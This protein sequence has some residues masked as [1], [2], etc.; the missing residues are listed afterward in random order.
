MR[1]FLTAT[2]A[3]TLFTAA[4]TFAP[5]TDTIEDTAPVTAATATQPNGLVET[6][7]FD[8]SAL[9][10]LVR[11]GVV[12]I[13]TRVITLDMLMRPVEL[14][15]TGSG[16]VIDDAGHIVTNFHV[17]AEAE[18]VTVI[19]ADGEPRQARVIGGDP[20]QDIA[21][22]KVSDTQG[23]EPL[24]MGSSDAMEVGN[25]VVAIGNALGLDATSPS[26]TVGI[27]SAKGRTVEVQP[28]TIRNALQTDAAINPGNSGGPLLN[29]L[30]QVIG[31]NTAIIQGAENIGFAIAIDEAKPIISQILSAVGQPFV[32]VSLVDNTPERAQRFGLATDTGAI[33]IDVLPGAPADDAGMRFGDII[34][35]VDGED[36]PDADAVVETILASSPGDTLEMT[37][38]R[39]STSGTIRVTV[40]ER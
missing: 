5:T 36:V 9:V 26:A 14:P 12:T 35:A 37:I 19:G 18:E 13:V 6:R 39:G 15:G 30:G 11:P 21:V 24:E 25:P 2:I 20:R 17:I 40:A 7:L 4:C 32:G 22:L 10:K 8:V 3:L 29:E 16:F 33:V 1:R 34:V 23:L 28:A 27:L 38:V 31:I